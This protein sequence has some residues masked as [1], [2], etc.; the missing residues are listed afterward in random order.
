[1]LAYFYWT[2]WPKFCFWWK[3]LAPHYWQH[4][5]GTLFS[6]VFVFSQPRKTEYSLRSP[7]T[8]PSYLQS[9][10]SITSQTTL[11]RSPSQASSIYLP[12][13]DMFPSTVSLSP[14]TPR[15]PQSMSS[16]LPSDTVPET[17]PETPMLEDTEPD[18]V[19]IEHFPEKEPPP[20]NLP[21]R[22]PR[23]ASANGPVR[24][25]ENVSSV[26]RQMSLSSVPRIPPRATTLER[27]PHLADDNEAAP[28]IPPREP[29]RGTR[30]SPPPVPP[31]MPPGNEPMTRHTEMSNQEDSV[32]PALPPKSRRSW[33]L[34][35]VVTCSTWHVLYDLISLLWSD[36]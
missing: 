14:G 16:F 18:Y 12:D 8:K 3:A 20:P 5:D 36:T 29:S 35:D 6:L 9:R 4:F 26:R 19:N 27:F 17:I 23:S 2:G 15:T 7:G 30:R 1:M 24:P 21:P 10:L 31:R 34:G 32:P 22:K 25:T 28:P 33:K 11:R 13:S